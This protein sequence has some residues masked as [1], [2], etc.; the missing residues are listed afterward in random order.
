MLF[1][2]EG[3]E[4]SLAR[5]GEGLQLAF[6]P[7]ESSGDLVKIGKVKREV[8]RAALPR[9]SAFF[10]QDPIPEGVVRGGQFFRSERFH[11]FLKQDGAGQDHIDAF[12]LHS[13]ECQ[14][15]L[16]GH[17][18]HPCV[19]LFEA[20]PFDR[21]AVSAGA[22]CHSGSIEPSKTLLAMGRTPEQR[23]ILAALRVLQA[24]V[25]ELRSTR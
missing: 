7:A 8:R 5:S 12:G 22:A 1:R 24:Q 9:Q 13:R 6:I 25:D 16:G 14:E 18:A 2:S 10:F 19:E 20:C 3:L 15:L 4:E 17:P 11:R 21:I 23:A